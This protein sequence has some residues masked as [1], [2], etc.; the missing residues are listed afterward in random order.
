MLQK[1]QEVRTWK[2]LY[3]I[4]G[5][6][7]FYGRVGAGKSYKLKSVAEYYYEKGMKLWDMFG[8]KRGEGPFWCFP[9]DELDL[10][11]EYE[12]YVGL[13]KSY[14]PKEY[15]VNL[16]YPYFKEHLPRELP[17]KK[18]RISCKLMTI[19][20]KDI[21]IQDISLVLGQVSQNAK[22]IWNY[23]LKHIPDNGNGQDI[24]NLFNKKFK[25][26][27]DL[28]LYKNFL[29]PL[30]DNQ[31]LV[32]K[33][34]E[35]NL[36]FIQEAKD[37]KNIFVLCDDYIPNDFKFFIMGYIMRT[38]FDLVKKDKIPRH[39]IAL[40]REMSLFMKV[41][42]S[43][44]QDDLQTQNFRNLISDIARYS[45]SGLYIAGDTQSPAEVKGLIEGQE[46]LL[47]ISEMP[48]AKDRE[49]A[50]EQM[51]KDK[52]ISASQ[53]SYISMMG[54]PEL[55]VIERGKRAVLIKRIQP[56]KTMCWNERT[57]NFFSVW[58]KLFNEYRDIGE[59]K[60]KIEEIYEKNK[61]NVLEDDE[62]EEGTEVMEVKVKKVEAAEIVE[63]KPKKS[64]VDLEIERLEEEI[65]NYKPVIRA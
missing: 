63:V 41:Q 18:P 26:H 65:K 33:N 45:R 29:L 36:D 60:D 62:D 31:I 20:F 51:R 30:I 27:K 2:P 21:T 5:N 43:G 6:I 47:C 40:F 49:V 23:I 13:M 50:L 24:L 1:T 52:R 59:I 61:Q 3:P 55:V 64:K 37:N 15:N 44:N 4:S 58:K 9:S 7:Y 28:S 8:G 48:S 11:K 32:G 42:D 34:F 17:E 54:K 39:N 38:L 57:G 22:Y 53:M 19:Y 12:K 16:V 56:P 25:K 10:W 14:G 35:F 46:D